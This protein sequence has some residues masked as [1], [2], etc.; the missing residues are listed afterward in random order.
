MPHTS[1][2]IDNIVLI[3]KYHKSCW[4]WNQH[5]LQNQWKLRIFE[6]K[7]EKYRK[8]QKFR[9]KNKIFQNMKF[10]KKHENFEKTQNL[11]KSKIL[12]K[13]W[14]FSKI[15][16]FEFFFWNFDFFFENIEILKNWEVFS[17]FWCTILKKILKH[18]SQFFSK[19]FN[20][21]WSKIIEDF[22][23]NFEKFEKA[24]KKSGKEAGKSGWLSTFNDPSRIPRNVYLGTCL[25]MITTNHYARH[26][27][28][29]PLASFSRPPARA[30]YPP[31]LQFYLYC[32]SQIEFG[33]YRRCRYKGWEKN[34]KWQC[35]R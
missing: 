1:K 7:N 32:S 11:K 17:I 20:K 9:K 3:L 19:F 28:D 25:H 31:P 33:W 29:L 14:N 6:A 35:F 2:C 16:K 26:G 23:H 10:F 21:F 27:S 13:K 18:I 15:E 4:K 30:P 24:G 34:V 12:K 22:L 8:S 5:Q